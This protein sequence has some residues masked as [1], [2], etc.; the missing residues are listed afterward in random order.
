[1]PEWGK[2]K[3]KRWGRSINS[4]LTLVG[5]SLLSSANLWPMVAE[6]KEEIKSYQWISN[7]A[8]RLISQQKRK[9][10]TK[11]KMD[12][13]ENSRHPGMSKLDRFPFSI[14]WWLKWFAAVGYIGCR[15]GLNVLIRFG[16]TQLPPPSGPHP[17]LTNSESWGTLSRKL[18]NKKME[19]SEQPKSCV[20]K[21]IQ[22]LRAAPA[23][24]VPLSLSLSNARATDSNSDGLLP[25]FVPLDPC[26]SIS[27]S[28]QHPPRNT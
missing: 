2:K 28:T 5:I 6:K 9:K 17:V 1:M 13:T 24:Y 21:M 23:R 10:K 19:E 18:K 27:P 7:S 22:R 16:V 14:W 20:Y 11:K 8:S 26:V 25:S 3:N 15:R 12:R 4:R